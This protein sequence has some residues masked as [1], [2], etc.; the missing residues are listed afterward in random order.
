MVSFSYMNF[1]LILI[2]EFSPLFFI[3]ISFIV[4]IEKKR[5]MI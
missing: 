3:Q 5:E 1:D 2:F 4:V